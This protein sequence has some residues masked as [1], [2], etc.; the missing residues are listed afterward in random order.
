MVVE[1]TQGPRKAQ[2]G[3]VVGEAR[4]M[5]LGVADIDVRFEDGHIRSMRPDY[6]GEMRVALPSSAV[7]E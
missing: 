2:R 5:Y 4:S 6:L 7:A 1:V 3:V